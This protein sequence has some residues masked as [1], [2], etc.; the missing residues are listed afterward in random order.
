[1]LRYQ[2]FAISAHFFQKKAKLRR[3]FAVEVCD[4]HGCRNDETRM[5]NVEGFR[6][7]VSKE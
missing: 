6:E 2:D 5:T 4:G 3:R 7:Q 1:M